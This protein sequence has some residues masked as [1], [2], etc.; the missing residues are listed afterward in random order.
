MNLGVSIYGAS[1]LEV[2]TDLDEY[3]IGRFKVQFLCLGEVEE[4][5]IT[6]CLYERDAED[7]LTELWYESVESLDTTYLP[8]LLELLCVILEQYPEV[9]EEI[10]HADL[11]VLQKSFETF[12]KSVQNE[13]ERRIQTCLEYEANMLKLVSRSK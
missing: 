10:P 6:V 2:P 11:L 13:H 9:A 1:L 5:Y 8:S 3:D 12:S 7:D 4:R